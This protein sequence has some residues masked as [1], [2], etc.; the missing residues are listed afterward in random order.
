MAAKGQSRRHIKKA[1]LRQLESDFDMRRFNYKELVRHVKGKSKL[2]GILTASVIYFIGV[3]GGYYG[4]TNGFVPEDVM[5]K[6]IFI[7]MVPSSVIGAV[8]WMITDSRM[9]YPLRKELSLYIASIEGEQ[10]RLWRYSPIVDTLTIKGVDIAKTIALS[11]EGLGENIDPQDYA[12]IVMALYKEVNS[13]EG[14]QLSGEDSK[15]L[16]EQLLNLNAAG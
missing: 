12:A 1:V 4:W 10:G 15:R 8:T 7:A 13:N 16:E 3:G 14:L 11:K 2:I 9:E 6:I 5:A